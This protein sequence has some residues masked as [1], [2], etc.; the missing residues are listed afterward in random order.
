MRHHPD[1]SAAI[2]RFRALLRDRGQ[3][4]TREREAIVE[5]LVSRSGHF[6]VEALLEALRERGLHA[7]RA[8]IYRALPLLLEAGL[9]HTTVSAHSEVRYET[10][11]GPH[12][13]HLVCQTCGKTVEFEFEAFE[14]LQ[15]GVAAKYGFELVDHVHALIGICPDCRKAGSKPPPRTDT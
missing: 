9:L 6:T 13:D 5:V 1:N 15:A 8:T 14:M 2:E 12:H 4:W 3:R 7:S 11:V 10:T